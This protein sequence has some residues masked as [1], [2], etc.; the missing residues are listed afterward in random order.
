MAIIRP[1]PGA[2]RSDRQAFDQIAD[3][4]EDEVGRICSRINFVRGPVPF[5][6]LLRSMFPVA[7]SLGDLIYQHEH[8]TQNLRCVLAREFNHVRRGYADKA[9]LLAYLYR[10]SLI[11]HDELRV[12]T[13]AGRS[14]GWA[15]SSDRNDRHLE[16]RR[17][18]KDY[19][20]VTFQPRVFY[21]DIL[22]VCNQGR[23]RRWKGIV[24][25]RY[26][27]WLS[28]DLDAAGGKGSV[29]PVKQE[30]AAL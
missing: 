12:V 8:P 14:V 5:W 21:D 26:N 18:R 1:L 27:A 17:V 24:M 29:K 15:V 9:A 30:I 11:H 3:R 20:R 23:S 16:V 6:A 4:F 19:Y 28:V 13:S 7:E 25:Q 10:H 22:A 2:V